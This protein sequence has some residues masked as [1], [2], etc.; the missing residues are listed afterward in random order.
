MDG[1]APQKQALET[2]VRATLGRAV[3]YATSLLGDAVQ[4]E[5]IVQ[6]CFCR[7]LQKQN[8]YDLERDGV[9]LL[10]RSISNACIN[11][12]KHE[13]RYR[14]LDDMSSRVDESGNV[15]DQRQP[16]PLAQAMQH[17]LEVALAEGLAKL[18]T[19][20]RAAFELKSLGY[21]QQEI[22]E[23]LDITPTYAGVLV[24]R[25]RLTLAEHL[26]SFQ[27]QHES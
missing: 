3:A 26:A 27:E 5:D 18:S 2:W 15:R 23:M 14:R 12:R 19:M 25:A 13:G 24:H 16:E 9:K 4:A 21:S 20:H 10:Y 11:W 6:D 8:I 22:A 7:L 17:E 1:F